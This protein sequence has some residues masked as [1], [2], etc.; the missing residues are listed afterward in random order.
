MSQ[1]TSTPPTDG[2]TGGSWCGDLRDLDASGV[3]AAVTAARRSADAQEAA[4]LAAGGA[5]GDL[6]PVTEHTPAA[7]WPGDQPLG[8]Q[9]GGRGAGGAVGGPPGAGGGAPPGAR[10]AVAGVRAGVGGG[11]RD[12]AGRRVRGRGARCRVGDQLPGRARPGR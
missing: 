1:T 11:G 9:Q 10:E 5:W 4:L 12:S 2:T 3:L 7:T 8:G 6:H